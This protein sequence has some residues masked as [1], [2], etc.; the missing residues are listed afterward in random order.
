M[1]VQG[2]DSGNTCWCDASG[3][4]VPPGAVEGGN[5]GETLFVGRAHHEGALIP[6]KVKPGHSVCYIPWGGGEHGKADY[7][8]SS[9]HHFEVFTVGLL[10]FSYSYYLFVHICI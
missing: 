2:L 6:G 5:D 3:G 4:M 10:S 1:A 9:W 7:Q 8:V